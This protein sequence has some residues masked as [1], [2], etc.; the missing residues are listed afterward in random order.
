VILEIRFAEANDQ[1]K[2]SN[3]YWKRILFS[4]QKTDGCCHFSPELKFMLHWNFR[5]GM[6][7]QNRV[8]IRIKLI[9]INIISIIKFAF[10]VLLF[11]NNTGDNTP[12]NMH[13]SSQNISR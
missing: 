9:F 12:N 11:D 4:V 5:G 3:L 13:K 1:D 2:I 7:A 8:E 10:S 6:L